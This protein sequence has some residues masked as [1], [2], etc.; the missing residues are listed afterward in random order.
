MA[1]PTV[2]AWRVAAASAVLLAALGCEELF[3]GVMEPTAFGNLFA[4]NREEDVAKVVARLPA[5]APATA[6][7][8]RLGRPL[9][10]G[11]RYGT[12]GVF[13]FD[14]S[15]GTMLWNKE[16]SVASRPVLTD[17]AVL[18]QSGSDVVSLRLE[19]GSEMWRIETEG[20]SFFGAAHDEKYAYLT[21]GVTVS[22]VG[23]LIAVNADSGWTSW[24]IQTTKLFG[25]P[26]AAGGLVFVPWERQ[27]ISV[28]DRESQEEIARIRSVDD[29]YNFV[30]AR[31]QG[32]FYGSKGLYRFD[33]KSFHGT[34][35]DATYYR[36]PM[37]G[38]PGDPELWADAFAEPTGGR[39]A[40]EKIRFFVAPAFDPAGQSVTLEHDKLFL[41][42]FRF[43][44]A[45]DAASGAIQWIYRHPDDIEAVSVQPSGVFLVDSPGNLVRVAADT[46]LPDWRLPIGIDVAAATFD[47]AG[48][49]PPS[50]PVGTVG[51]MRVQL[52]Q[53]ILDQDN[54]LLPFRQYLI[55]KLAQ[56]PEPE[57]TRDIL[58]V[59]AQR[60]SPQAL[61][62]AARAA[63]ASRAQGAEHLIGALDTHTDYLMNTQ[64]PPMGVV[65]QSLV[66]MQARAAVTGLVAH[67]LDPETPLE[68]LQEVAQALV[69]LGDASLISTFESYL[70]LYHADSAFSQNPNA[71]NV[72]ADGLLKYGGEEERR[73]LDNLVASTYTLPALKAHIQKRYDEI[74]QARLAAEEAARLAAEA[75]AAGTVSAVQEVLPQTLSRE[76]VGQAMTANA[77]LIA[78]CVQA[79]MQRSPTLS[80]VRMVFRLSN[81]GQASDLSV[82][83]SD[84]AEFT[85]CL[86][87]AL[88][89]IQFPRFLALSQRAQFTIDIATP[90]PP[91]GTA[92][93]TPPPGP[94]TPPTPILPGTPIVPTGPVGPVAPPPPPPGVPGAGTTSVPVAPLPPPPPPPGVPGAGTVPVTPLPPPPPP[95][96]VPGTGTVPVTPV[97]PPPPPPGVPGATGTGAATTPT[98]PGA[99]T[100]PPPVAN[101][102]EYPDVLPPE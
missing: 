32:V 17:R 81:T 53:V 102:D 21:L 79:K 9:V 54:R 85:A 69:D 97:A 68:D 101:P 60:T 55:A 77:A 57:V 24:K 99:G 86:S 34:Q 43:L 40:R 33:G 26:A 89:Q 29:V 72:L 59:Y 87:E 4:D 90:E 39:N 88:S 51:T 65:A 30:F 74:E 56:L 92:P 62:D 37:Q 12:P 7:A 76:Q 80:Q 28:L 84:D 93:G 42:Y 20:M 35:Q 58:D 2:M 27:D 70:T 73:F 11:L 18:V 1:R 49:S 22:H 83:P 13:V 64:A 48:F 38:I 23:R 61:K 100:P 6:P 14:V 66:A 36:P 45:Y 31:P 82:L 78:P 15:T 67:L 47:I 8:N 50:Q 91:P 10:A 25:R 44:V 19:D 71:L 46:G 52:L 75:A 96:G 3:G 5:P 16:M 98:T 41:L 95:P 63:L 94:G